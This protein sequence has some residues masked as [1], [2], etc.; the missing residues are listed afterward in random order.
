MLPQWYSAYVH[1]HE[2]PQGSSIDVE[3]GGAIDADEDGEPDLNSETSFAT[4]IDAVG[5]RHLL[6]FRIVLRPN[7]QG[8][9]PVVAAI[10]IPYEETASA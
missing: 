1:V 3:Y 9:V 7:A 2:L 10:A 4:V 8:E 5:R 6:R